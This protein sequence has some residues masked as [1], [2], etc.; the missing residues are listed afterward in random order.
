MDIAPTP[1]FH[2]GRFAA[3]RPLRRGRRHRPPPPRAPP[4]QKTY[5]PLSKSYFPFPSKKRSPFC[6]LPPHIVKTLPYSF[7]LTNATSFKDLQNTLDALRQRSR[8]MD[9]YAFT[10]RFLQTIQMDFAPSPFYIPN[11][12]L[13]SLIAVLFQNQQVR[14]AFKRLLTEWV[15]KRR[16][17]E[18][19]DMDIVTCEIPRQP[20]HILYW[21]ARSQYVFEAR[22]LHKDMVERLLHHDDLWIHP[23]SPRN[24][25]TNMNMSPWDVHRCIQKCRAYGLTHWTTEAFHSCQYNLEIFQ[26][27]YTIPLKL[28]ALRRMFQGNELGQDTKEFLIDFIEQEHGH[29]EIAFHDS[30]YRWALDK[31]PTNKIVQEWIRICKLFYE[32]H[33]TIRDAGELDLKQIKLINPITKRLCS[34][35]DT[36]ISARNLWHRQRLLAATARRGKGGE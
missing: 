30:V 32:L 27:N 28:S 34:V 14:F 31:I 21:P 9:E 33:I 26:R 4:V 25:F 23:L 5:Y 10:R 11:T 36:L 35:V 7:P 2:P 1:A 18:I 29:F 22:T 3:P 15:C 6:I 19:N 17:K 24:P 8:H 20:I 16:I 13:N 12:V